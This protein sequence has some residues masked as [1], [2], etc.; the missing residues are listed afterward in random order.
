MER[1]EEETRKR[2]EVAQERRRRLLADEAADE[3]RQ[4]K[5]VQVEKAVRKGTISGKHEKDK[6]KIIKLICLRTAGFPNDGAIG[7]DHVIHAGITSGNDNV[8]GSVGG[9]EAGEK[10]DEEEKE[11][12]AEGGGRLEQGRLTAWLREHG[13]QWLKRVSLMKV[14]DQFGCMRELV[15]R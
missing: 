1:E 10:G 4:A 7:G 2:F 11:E 15:G 13:E 8:G 5:R 6:R 3:A 14:A 9:G 12:G